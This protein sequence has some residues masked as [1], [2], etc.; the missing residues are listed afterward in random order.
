MYVLASYRAWHDHIFCRTAT[1]ILR[2]ILER[3]GA[4][5]PPSLI[6]LD[7]SGGSAVYQIGPT[8]KPASLFTTPLIATMQLGTTQNYHCTVAFVNIL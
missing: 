7:S 8:H 1:H 2:D 3:E 4:V 5:C 6:S